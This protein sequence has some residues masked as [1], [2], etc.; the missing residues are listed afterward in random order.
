MGIGGRE[1]E[2]GSFGWLLARGCLVL[3]SDRGCDWSLGRD[4]V[5]ED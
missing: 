2:R 3:L 4:G 5:T 1:R